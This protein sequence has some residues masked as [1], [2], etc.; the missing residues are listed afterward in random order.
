MTH[1][2][3]VD[4]YLAKNPLFLTYYWIAY[5]TYY[6]DMNKTKKQL[7]GPKLGQYTF[8]FHQAYF[9]SVRCLDNNLKGR[10]V[11]G[12]IGACII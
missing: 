5:K 3:S 11:G 9:K 10:E 8:E 12:S 6:Q 1:T 4:H 2:S 7:L